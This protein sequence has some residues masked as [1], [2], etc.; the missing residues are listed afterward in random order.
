VAPEDLLHDPH[1]SLDAEYYISKNLIPPLE[2]I[3]NLVGANVRQWYDE[4]PKVRRIRRVDTTSVTGAAN[5]AGWKK[6]K[7]LEAYLKSASCAVCG[8]KMNKGRVGMVCS[9][10]R[11]DVA[12]SMMKMQRRLNNDE[13]R[14]RGAVNVCQTCAGLAPLD[15]EVQ[16]DSKD[17]PV[18]YSRVKL[19]SRVRTER[20]IVESVLSELEDPNVGRRGLEW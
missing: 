14:L 17:C 8:V 16:C 15:T 12:G 18:F 3:F 13:E 10:C 20:S 6:K 9:R 2:R 1:S 4:M 19:A 7:T 5:G 11:R